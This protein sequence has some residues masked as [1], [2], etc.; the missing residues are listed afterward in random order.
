M[1][2]LLVILLMMGMRYDEIKDVQNKP[3]RIMISEVMAKNLSG[4]QDVDGD[5]SD[6]IEIHNATGET[7]NL[8]GYGLSDSAVEPYKWTFPEISLGPDEYLIV[9]ASGKDVIREDEIHL[10]FSLDSTAETLVLTSAEGETMDVFS[11]QDMEWD[12]SYGRSGWNTADLGYFNQA[13]PGEDNP[14]EFLTSQ[15]MTIADIGAVEF[16]VQGGFFE[17]SFLLELSCDDEDALIVY[18]TDGSEPGIGSEIYTEP[19]LIE[20]VTDSPNQW[21][22]VPCITSDRYN[23]EYGINN[24]EKCNVIRARIYKDGVFSEI[25]TTNSYFVGLGYSMPVVSITTEPEKLFNSK[26]GMYVPGEIYWLGSDSGLLYR[27]RCGSMYYGN[28]SSGCVEIWD[29][30]GQQIFESDMVLKVSGEASRGALLQKA[31]NIECMEGKYIDSQRKTYTDVLNLKSLGGGST[32]PL[33]YQNHLLA[34]LANELEIGAAGGEFVIVFLDGE[35]WGI[36]YLQDRLNSEYINRE[37][38]ISEDN[39]YCISSGREYATLTWKA[40]AGGQKAIDAV[41]ELYREICERD[42]TVEEDY[43]WICEQID[44]DNFM[45]YI[46]FEL[47]TG[48]I[49]WLNNKNNNV[50]MFR[51]A[52]KEEGSTCADTRW[53]WIAYD[54]DLSME[55]PQAANL[56]SLLAYQPNAD[57]TDCKKERYLT[58]VLF[59]KL[60]ENPEF[61]R[62]YGI[63]TM[64]LLEGVLSTEHVTELWN[65]Q[66]A[67]LEPEMEKN[68]SRLELDY[69][70]KEKLLKTLY[71]ESTIYWSNMTM[72]TW[73]SNVESVYQF[74]AERGDYIRPYIIEY[75]DIGDVYQ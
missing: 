63:K 23:L 37:Y 55:S 3:E 66:V 49:D 10:N 60:W 73:Y 59:Q 44:V 58:L 75:T 25:I 50:I 7:L 47:Y 27:K 69:T 14:M 62:A 15:N 20:D 36:Y 33:A 52:E 71:G 41:N 32:Y 2:P 12:I 70:D 21:V 45:T 42:F 74:I 72:E 65:T 61:K 5:Y 46:A 30:A 57:E 35:Y 67:C 39:L 34:D 56:S 18:T 28:T 54:M 13:T 16:S 51:S 26:D 31:F 1:F 48:N 11:F 19:I 17:D 22:S 68:L 29:Q 8:A 53:R 64:E 6:W 24:V 4:L 38:G 9:W 40:D 43:Q